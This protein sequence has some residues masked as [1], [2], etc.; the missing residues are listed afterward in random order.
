MLGKSIRER[1]VKE[2]AND[3]SGVFFCGPK[4]LGSSLHLKCN[5]Y[6]DPDWSYVW[7]KENF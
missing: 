1:D 6:S 7:G 4:G 3:C 5:E 2:S